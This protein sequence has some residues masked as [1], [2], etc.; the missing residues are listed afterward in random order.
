MLIV[1]C[2]AF[3]LIS[4]AFLFAGCIKKRPWLV[5]AGACIWILTVG[6][7]ARALG[8]EIKAYRIEIVHSDMKQEN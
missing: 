1:V 4:L 5:L 2:F 3:Y 8:D 6:T 7:L